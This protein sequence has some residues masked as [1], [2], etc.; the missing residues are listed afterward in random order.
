MPHNP[1]AER[2]V[3]GAILAQNGCLPDVRELLTPEDFYVSQHLHLFSH[4]LGLYD[5]GAPVDLVTLI[6]KLQNEMELELVGGAA[7]VSS[8]ADGMPRIINA[9]HYARIVKEASLL[10]AL[11]HMVEAIQQQAYSHERSV[12]ILAEAR[13][14]LNLLEEL[15]PRRGPW[16]IK[17]IVQ[18]STPDLDRIFNEKSSVTGLPTGYPKLDQY[19]AGLHDAELVVIAARPGVGKSSLALNIV[20]KVALAAGHPVLLFSIEMNRRALLYRMVASHESIDAHKFRT[21]N[22]DAE[23]RRRISDCT[24]L[25]I[26]EAPLWIDDSSVLT[27]GE[28]G[29]RA[30]RIA[31]D[32]RLRLVVVDYLQLVSAGRR[33]GN[34]QEEVSE[35]SRGL[36]ALAKNLNLPV[37]ALS[38][39]RRATD[40]EHGPMLS[41]LRESGAIEQ[42]ADVVLFIH[43]PDVYKKKKDDG[44]ARA[45][46]D[47]VPADVIIA[48]QRNGPV[49]TVKFKFLPHYTRFEELHKEERELF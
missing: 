33:F 40:E 11:I 39:L 21:G 32:H 46:A 18:D 4:M 27:L 14:R 24:V 45:A 37:I 19:L 12:G 31:R 42:D 1:E 20:E 9:G 41:D 23:Q 49:A 44:P 34:R 6:D 2:S 17:E 25:T 3:L 15:Q 5:Q 26:G 43:R 36:K 30:A 16:T 7:Y 22:F 48:K 10:R 13:S 47:G 28:L 8:L 35:I 29:A 38:Q